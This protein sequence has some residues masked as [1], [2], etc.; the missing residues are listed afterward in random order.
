MPLERRS[1]M[2]VV[3]CVGS[4]LCDRLI[5]CSEKSTLCLC[6]CV[7]VCDLET[8][9]IRGLRAETAC[10]TAQ[11]NRRIFNIFLYNA[12]LIKHKFILF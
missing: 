8:S 9:P 4:G 6:V 1:Y 11:N 5:T 10:Y 12:I 3:F 2:F 7:C